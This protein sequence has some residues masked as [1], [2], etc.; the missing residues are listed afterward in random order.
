MSTY[1]IFINISLI[2]LTIILTTLIIYLTPLRY[3]HL[4][5]PSIDDISATDFYEKYTADPSK[6]IFLDVRGESSYNN[7]HADGSINMPVHLLYHERHNLPRKDQEIVLICSGGVA[8][9]VGYSYLEHYGFTNINRI[10]GGIE[11][12]LEAGLPTNGTEN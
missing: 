2:L 10:E 8:S 5:Q 11:S 7:L 4:I 1:K 12:W 9:G 6:Y 3:T